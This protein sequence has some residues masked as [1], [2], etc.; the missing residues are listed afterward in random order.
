VVHLGLDDAVLGLPD[1]RQ[2]ERLALQKTGGRCYAHS[3]LR[4]STNFRRKKKISVI[5]PWRK[6]EMVHFY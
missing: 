4:F 2:H 3:F 6:R 1:R 5:L